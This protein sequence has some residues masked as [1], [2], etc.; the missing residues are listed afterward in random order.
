MKRALLIVGVIALGLAVSLGA[1]SAL[2]VPI[3][4]IY[5]EGGT[6][7]QATE[8]WELTPEGSS[9]GG[10]F[11]VW[12]IGNVDGPGGKGIIE[13]VRLSI[14]Y[15]E[16]VDVGITLTPTTAGGVGSYNGVTDP[17]APD[18]PVQLTLI[19]TSL[20]QFDTSTTNGVV[21]NGSQPVLGDGSSLPAHGE[22]G[23][24]RVWEEWYL[25]DMGLT[26]SD[27]GDFIGGF[28]TDLDANS[29]MVNV[30]DVSVTGGHGV[31]L[32]FDVY[33]HVGAENHGKYKFAPF[34]HDADGDVNV[35]PEPA[36]LAIWSVLGLVGVGGY[37]RRSRRKNKKAA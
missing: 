35:V 1:R 27:I 34:S 4:Q 31:T 16:G 2:A 23:T 24:G 19:Q 9:A 28:P 12:V 6:Y 29:G 25:G 26:D 11:R 13:D 18:A 14:V 22:Y 5:L 15:D 10:P 20:G 21:T 37:W 3:L 17:L 36:T 30:Y 32:H 7:N 33:N 8:S